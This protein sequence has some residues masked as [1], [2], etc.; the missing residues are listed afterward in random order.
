MGWVGA[1]VGYVATDAF[2]DGGFDG[3]SASVDRN[4]VTARARIGVMGEYENFAVSY[5]VNWLSAEFDGQ[6][7]GQVIGAL[8]IKYRF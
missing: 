3:N 8:Q 1:D 4:E 5:S 6:P 2:L 7:E